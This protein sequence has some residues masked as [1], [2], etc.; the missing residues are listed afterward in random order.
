MLLYMLSVSVS[1]WVIFFGGAKSISN[2][3]L[4][5]FEFGPAASSSSYIYMLAWVNLFFFGGLLISK[6]V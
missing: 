6:V 3:L 5:Y 1:I 2:T 4:G